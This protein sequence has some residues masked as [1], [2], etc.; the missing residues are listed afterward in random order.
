[1]S[2]FIAV[3]LVSAALA[4]ALLVPIAAL[5]RGT[6]THRWL[7]RGW[8]AAILVTCVSSFGIHG[9]DLFWGFSPIHLLS[10]W[11]MGATA[12]A[13]HAI[14]RGRPSAHRK[15]MIGV[16]AGL[17]I[18]FAFTFLPGRILGNAVARLF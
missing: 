12:Y 18:A 6:P 8:V 15:A 4:L 2:P 14:R 1:M 17:L 16:A 3:H 9:F 10:L 11:T 5:P 7:G 13:V